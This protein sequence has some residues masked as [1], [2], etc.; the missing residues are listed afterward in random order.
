MV[1]LWQVEDRAT[2]LLMKRFYEN[3]LGKYEEER[4]GQVGEPMPKAE[5]LQEAKRWLRN[6]EENGKRPYEHPNFWSAFIFRIVAGIALAGTYMPG[7]K[8]LSDHL[9]QMTGGKDQSRAIA[10]YTS[11]F[12]IGTALSF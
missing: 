3:W 2:A 8:L 1:S 4:G 10:F 11:S 9:S 12:C 5:A 7:L 6:Y